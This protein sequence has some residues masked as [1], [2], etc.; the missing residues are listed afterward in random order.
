[1]RWRKWVVAPVLLAV[2][3]MS[4]A[5]PSSAA[6][7]PVPPNSKAFGRSLTA[8]MTAYFEQ[9]FGR[10]TDTGK[11]V[12]L[13]PL[14]VGVWQGDGSFTSQDPS[15]F[16]GSLDVSLKPGTPFVLPIAAWFGESYNNGLPDDAPLSSSVFTGSHVLVKM[17]GSALVNSQADN[18]ARW[19]FGPTYFDPPITYD[20][21]TDYGSI[22]ANFIQGLG[23]R[24][25][26]QS[27]GTHLLT[28]ESEV[29]ASVPNY[30]GPGLDLDVGVKYQNSWTI[31]VTN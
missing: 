21:P 17:D 16:V 3:G 11:H 24:V 22:A 6:P 12:S 27:R 26:P 29:I 8:W 31:H 1:M 5:G 7:K 25:Q 18:L 14:P 28:L 13:L 19:Y 4:F 2:V 9:A 23:L 10:P 30:Y 20:Q 15:T